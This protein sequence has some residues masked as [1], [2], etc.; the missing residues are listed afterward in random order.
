MFY[1]NSSSYS[2]H[3]YVRGADGREY[4]TPKTS[5]SFSPSAERK[6]SSKYNGTCVSCRQSF[7]A[8]TQILWSKAAG[9]KH[10]QCPVVEER[11]AAKVS[12]Q[13]AEIEALALE[14]E[15]AG[16]DDEAVLA[17]MDALAD[18]VGTMNDNA[19]Q[20]DAEIADEADELLTRYHAAI[21]AQLEETRREHGAGGTMGHDELAEV[22]NRQA[23]RRLNSP[24]GGKTEEQIASEADALLDAY[25]AERRA[26][27]LQ[28]IVTRKLVYRVNLTGEA[29]RYGVDLV[30]VQIV[31]SAQYK[32]AKIGEFRG[33]A[34]GLLRQDGTIRYWNDVNPDD[35]R[36]KAVVAAVDV[37][38]ETAD[39][40]TMAQAYAL[41]AKECARCGDALV[42]DGNPFYPFFGPVCGR[43]FGKGE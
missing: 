2:A 16:D 43:K 22:W 37:L 6:M 8:G 30:N 10:V 28:T 1:G 25:E 5:S 18:R 13:D 42:D 15:L 12:A 21:D 27:A 20:A 35:A 34:V 36:V 17:A 3:R 33:I 41:E 40:I 19:A 4:F 24:S 11:A 29:T 23:K 7:P 39:P 31:P 38:L 14:A 9:A 26:S 32:N